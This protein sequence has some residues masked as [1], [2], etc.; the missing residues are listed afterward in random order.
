MKTLISIRKLKEVEKQ[1]M[2]LIYCIEGMTN[3]YNWFVE[4]YYIPKE[5]ALG[6]FSEKYPIENVDP[7]YH[8]NA[9]GQIEI[10]Q[11]YYNIIKERK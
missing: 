3:F 10:A 2:Y 11:T 1:N 6:K 5:Y 8:T 4:K 7:G 9:Q